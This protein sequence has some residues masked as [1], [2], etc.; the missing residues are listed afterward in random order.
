MEGQP[1]IQLVHDWFQRVWVLREPNAVEDMCTPGLIVHGMG[2]EPIIGASNFRTGVV[3][4]FSAQ[5]PEI[6]T[7]VHGVV[8]NGDH[9]GVRVRFTLRHKTKGWMMME[10]ATFVRYEGV[11]I[12]EAW[13][14]IDFLSLLIQTGAVSEDAMVALLYD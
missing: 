5:F 9:A 14:Y 12:A 7:E 3:D 8:L 4:T 6:Q 13:N 11:K 2:P 1:T 10:G